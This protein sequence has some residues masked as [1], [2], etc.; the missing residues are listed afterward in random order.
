MLNFDLEAEFKSVCDFSASVNWILLSH[1]LHSDDLEF[2]CN[3]WF[4]YLVFSNSLYKISM[5]NVWFVLHLFLEPVWF[6]IYFVMLDALWAIHEFPTSF[7]LTKCVW[8][9]S[10]NNKIWILD[11]FRISQDSN[12][13]TILYVCSCSVV[14]SQVIYWRELSKLRSR[15]VLM[16][17]TESASAFKPVLITWKRGL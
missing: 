7:R 11:R 10:C 5:C 12:T 16:E 9:D 3:S 4:W 6:C 1:L 13:L 14:K 2:Y 15:S 17:T 8:S